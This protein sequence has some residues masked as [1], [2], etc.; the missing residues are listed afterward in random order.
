MTFLVRN[1]NQNTF[2]CHDCILGNSPCLRH[3]NPQPRPRPVGIFGEFHERKK[4]KLLRDVCARDPE[5]TRKYPRNLTNW[6]TPKNLTKRNLEMMVSNRNL[7]FQGSI[8]RF[9]VCFGG[10]TKNSGQFITTFRNRRLVGPQMVVIARE[11]SPKM[12][13]NWVKDL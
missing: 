10:C 13:L 2:I 12:A 11:V 6:Y 7:I 8:F 9:H 3:S 5:A 4:R 1:P